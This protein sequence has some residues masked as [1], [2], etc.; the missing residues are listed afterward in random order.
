MPIVN[1]AAKVL[2]ISTIVTILTLSDQ[3]HDF[4]E[5]CGDLGDRFTE[6][7]VSGHG[8]VIPCNK[9]VITPKLGL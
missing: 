5:G 8:A 7:L 1:P 6:C 3:E 2:C 9:N 4:F